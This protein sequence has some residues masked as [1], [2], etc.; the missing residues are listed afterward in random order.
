MF[1]AA[2]ALPHITGGEPCGV[3]D[4]GQQEQLA[5]VI[6]GHADGHMLFGILSKLRHDQAGGV[7]LTRAAAGGEQYTPGISGSV[8]LGR[9]GKAFPVFAGFSELHQLLRG[10]PAEP[11]FDGVTAAA[12]V[13]GSD[14]RTKLSAVEH[15]AELQPVGNVDIDLDVRSHAL[16]LRPALVI[17]AEGQVSLAVAEGVRKAL[18]KAVLRVYPRDL[19]T[20]PVVCHVTSPSS[21]SD[22]WMISRRAVLFRSNWVMKSSPVS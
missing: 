4:P 22:F 3:V 7:F 20:I 17:G 1:S 6:K 21:C 19:V 14:G 9:A 18:H 10:G 13:L 5:Q 2:I 15:T 11:L 8:K 12:P 16:P